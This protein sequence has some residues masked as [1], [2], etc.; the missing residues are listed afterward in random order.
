M[1]NEPEV[2]EFDLNF[3][4]QPDGDGGSGGHQDVAVTKTGSSWT[5]SSSVAAALTVVK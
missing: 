3:A 2:P 4:I 5:N 1:R